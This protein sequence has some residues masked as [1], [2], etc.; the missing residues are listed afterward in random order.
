MSDI[1]PPF[2]SVIMPTYNHAHYIGRAIQSLVNQNYVNWELIVIDNHSIDNTENVVAG[3]FDPRISYLKIHNNGVIALSRNVGIREAKGEWIAFLD[4]DDW[5]SCDKL[6]VCCDS[7]R[8]DIDIIYHDLLIEEAQQSFFYSRKALKSRQVQ[9]PVLLDLLVNGNFIA[10]SSVVVRKSLLEKIGLI[11]ENP[12][13]VASEDYNTWLRVSEISEG[14]LHIDKILG[15]Y[16]VNQYGMSKKDMTI[17][18]RCS[19]DK[20][21]HLFSKHEKMLFDCI[22]AYE[23][24][25]YSHIHYDYESAVRN[26]KYCLKA[27]PV[28]LRIKALYRLVFSYMGLY[29][30]I[31]SIKLFQEKK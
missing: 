22:T 4:S 30:S 5:W 21:I 29:K 20:Y 8:S 31:L 25:K 9:S 6:K 23:S 3:F 14:F 12:E 2:V 17:P 27:A 1:K 16:M 28:L 15:F 26:F 11:D 10:N 13:M 7:I 19:V 24:G 18:W